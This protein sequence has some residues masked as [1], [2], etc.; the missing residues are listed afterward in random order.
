MEAR[1]YL[2]GAGQGPS[3]YT[4]PCGAYLR[5]VIPPP[6]VIPNPGGASPG[7]S[8]P[9]SVSMANQWVKFAV[10][11]H[12][13]GFILKGDSHM[14]LAF[15]QPSCGNPDAPNTFAAQAG[16]QWASGRSWDTLWVWQSPLSLGA[17]ICFMLEPG[18]FVDYFGIA[19]APMSFKIRSHATG[20]V[21]PNEIKPLAGQIGVVV[22]NDTG[23]TA[24][25]GE[26]S[27]E[28]IAG[29]FTP[30]DDGQDQHFATQDSV[31]YTAPGGVLPLKSLH[32]IP[33]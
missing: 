12:Y 31:W 16:K 29:N 25:L 23:I 24:N 9:P 6:Q 26:N 11:R 2:T 1:D 10:P 7:A 15:C 18:A 3:A 19:N 30:L 5:V 27:A 13:H 28:I 32:I 14:R 20:N 22:L 4:K 21:L 33:K 17:E 8:G